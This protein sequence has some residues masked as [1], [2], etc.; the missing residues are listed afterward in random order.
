MALKADLDRQQQRSDLQPDVYTRELKM[1]VPLH[2]SVQWP[3]ALNELFVQLAEAARNPGPSTPC[4]DDDEEEFNLMPALKV[5]GAVCVGAITL[6]WIWRSYF[7]ISR[8]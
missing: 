7:Q 4:F 5:A 2:V 1:P 8:S 6:S 3:S